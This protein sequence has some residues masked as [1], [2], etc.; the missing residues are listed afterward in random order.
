MGT[1]H[2]LSDYGH[3]QSSKIPPKQKPWKPFRTRLDFEICELALECYLN[4]AQLKKLITLVNEAIAI[5]P[6]N[7]NEGFTIKS[8]SEVEK[9]WKLTTDEHV[10]VS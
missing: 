8:V 4:N 7:E 2:S 6:N 3:H 1:T 5:G 9:L 10:K